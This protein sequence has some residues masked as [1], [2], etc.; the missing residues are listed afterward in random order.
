MNKLMI[1]AL[2]FCAGCSVASDSPVEV[3]PKNEFLTNDDAAS[4]TM[5]PSSPWFVCGD[6]IVHEVIVNN[7]TYLIEEP[8][9]CT[10]SVP[11]EEFG[12]DPRSDFYGRIKIIEH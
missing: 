4:M 1:F 3:P 6:T 10:E 7:V 2:A 8:V 11:H 5:P 12:E 9:A